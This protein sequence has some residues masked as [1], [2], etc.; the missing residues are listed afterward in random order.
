MHGLHTEDTFE[1]FGVDSRYHEVRT[2]EIPLQVASD[3]RVKQIHVSAIRRVQ[4]P[5]DLTC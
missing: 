2:G 3:D 4:F 1:F 5:V